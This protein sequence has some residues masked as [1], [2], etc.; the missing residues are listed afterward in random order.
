MSTIETLQKCYISRELLVNGDT[1]L[2]TLK[3]N[4]IDTSAFKMSSTTKKGF[5]L[6]S[7][8]NGTGQWKPLPVFSQWETNKSNDHIF[9]KKGSVGI[10]VNNP[11]EMLHVVD[12][13]CVDGFLKVG[14]ALRMVSEGAHILKNDTFSIK[15][16]KDHVLYITKANNVGINTMS[17]DEK[18][19]VEGNVKLSGNIINNKNVFSLPDNSD[20]LVG[21][22]NKQTLNQKTLVSPTLMTPIINDPI[23]NGDIQLNNNS[24]IRGMRQP[25]TSNEVA[26]KEYVDILSVMNS[27]NFLDNVDAIITT[28]PENPGMDSRYIVNIKDDEWGDKYMQI[29]G[30]D[31]L[32]WIFEKPVQNNVVFVKAENEQWVYMENTNRWITYAGIVSSHSKMTDI[33]RDDHKQYMNI[34]GR[35]GGQ[36]M[37]GGTKKHDCLTIDSTTHVNKGNIILNGVGGNVGIGIREPTETLD[38]C[39]NVKISG[40]IVSNDNNVYEL[41]KSA[42]GG[43]TSQVTSLVSTESVD[44]LCNKTMVNPVIDGNIKGN[45]LSVTQIKNS[46][47]LS[48]EQLILVMS[49]ATLTLP[50]AYEHAGREYTI[51]ISK[52]DTVCNINTSGY[53]RINANE[54][55]KVLTEPHIPVRFVSDGVHRW[56]KM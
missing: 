22:K 39:G 2:N 41:P 48:E 35:E 42:V 33:E 8:N 7:S 47:V 54:R 21:E 51:I 3:T 30:W 15:T 5:V 17:A 43:M 16:R 28:I 45:R 20:V 38:I 32:E 37:I 34:Q 24:T 53:D 49:N 12:N 27:I 52:N 29:A 23:I 40:R 4:E 25:I 1:K 50:E 56:Y 31:G 10:G 14:G 9:Y 55:K 36:H 18:L 19:V 11:D 46:T 6:T 26:T 13:A 44:R